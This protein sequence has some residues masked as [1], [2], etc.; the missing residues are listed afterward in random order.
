MSK[1]HTLVALVALAL[2]L[3]AALL[4]AGKPV[5]DF[6]TVVILGGLGAVGIG[7]GSKF[8]TKRARRRVR[9]A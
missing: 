4:L 6:L 3:A 2:V 8:S 9:G 1:F 7:G 5:P